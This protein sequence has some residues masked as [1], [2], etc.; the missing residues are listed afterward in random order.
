MSIFYTQFNEY[1]NGRDFIIG[2]QY[3]AADIVALCT[4]DFLEQYA[5]ISI[6]PEY[7]ALVSWYARCARRPSS[8]A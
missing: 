7:S 3:S 1:L 4:V 8:N 6:A 5:G 2:D